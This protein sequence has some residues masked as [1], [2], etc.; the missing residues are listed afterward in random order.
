MKKENKVLKVLKLYLLIAPAM[1]GI[2]LFSIYPI[3]KLV[4]MSFYNIN[5]LNPSRTRF[6]GLDNYKKVFALESFHKALSNTAVYT[7]FSVIFILSLAVLMAVWLGRKSSKMNSITQT[8]I[9]TPHIISMISIALIWIWLMD[10]NYGLLNVIL[11]ALGL[12]PLKWLQSSDTSLMSI[13]LVSIWKSVGYY[14]ILLIAA[15]QNIPAEI[16]EAADLDNAGKFTTLRKITFPMISPQIFFSLIVM[17]IGSFKV[18]ETVRV[19][20]NGG[21]NNSTN[22]LVFMIY[23]EVFQNARVGHGAAVGVVLVAIVAVLTAIYFYGLAKKVHY[24]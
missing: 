22:T 2:F 15:L 9:F 10:P 11:K 1:I 13:T 17:T 16:Y 23:E 14:T 7:L 5:Q 21:P 4:S 8:A 20:T 12:K 19:M 24:Q 18:F 6:V 3:F